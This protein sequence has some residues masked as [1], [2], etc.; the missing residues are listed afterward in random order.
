[1][2]EEVEEIEDEGGVNAEMVATMKAKKSKLMQHLLLPERKRL[3]IV[4]T[5]C[6]VVDALW[7][8]DIH[9]RLLWYLLIQS[10]SSSFLM[11]S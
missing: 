5:S 11:W 4:V 2:R 7:R 9:H 6:V 8:Y 10:S 1:M 3:A